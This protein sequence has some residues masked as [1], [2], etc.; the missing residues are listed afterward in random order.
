M[1]L[2]DK[3]PYDKI[4]VSDITQKAGIARQTFYHNYHKKS[5]IIE[6]YIMKSF[7]IESLAPENGKGVA[8]KASLVLTLILDI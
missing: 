3:K 2:I 6:Q 7:D 4:T 5:D 8:K 1:L